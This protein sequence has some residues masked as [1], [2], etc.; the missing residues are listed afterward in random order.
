MNITDVLN[1]GL[2]SQNR[3]ADLNR[4][5]TARIN[6]ADHSRVSGLFKELI[7]IADETDIKQLAEKEERLDGL[8]SD[9]SVMRIDILKETVL[10]RSLRLTNDSYLED[11]QEDIKTAEAYTDPALSGSFPKT[12]NLLETL[13][14]RIAELKLT[15]SVGLSFSEQI[16]LT[17]NNLTSLSDRITDML[18]NLIPLLRGRISTEHSRIL[19]REIQNMM[20]GLYTA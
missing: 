2:G 12:S 4:L 13:N 20:T 17:E 10:L 19:I 9:L 1:I 3:L 5:V 7:S 11:L 16:K 14:K 6:S 18:V 15:R 8:C